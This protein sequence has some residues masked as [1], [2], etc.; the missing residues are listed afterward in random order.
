MTLASANTLLGSV[1]GKKGFHMCFAVCHRGSGNCVLMSLCRGNYT[2]LGQVKKIDAN[3][4]EICGLLLEACNNVRV[5]AIA[6]FELAQ[7]R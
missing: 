6:M 2:D 5:H 3:L 7:G 1:V 4:Q